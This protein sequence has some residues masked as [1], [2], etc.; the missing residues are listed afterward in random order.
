RDLRQLPGY[1]GRMAL[2][3]W[4]SGSFFFYVHVYESGQD[5]PKSDYIFSEQ[6]NKVNFPDLQPAW[7]LPEGQQL[8][9]LAA[10]PVSQEDI[11][12]ARTKDSAFALQKVVERGEI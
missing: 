10:V 7:Q 3:P 11:L 2:Y 12:V 9:L 4:L 5:G 8:R 1:I 6:L